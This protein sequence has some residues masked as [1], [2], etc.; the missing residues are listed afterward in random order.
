MIVAACM[1]ALIA[2][3]WGASLYVRKASAYLEA[4]DSVWDSLYLAAKKVIEDPAMP[5]EFAGFAAASVICAGCGC[6]TRAI[7]VDSALSVFRRRKKREKSWPEVSPEQ[8]AAFDAV[9]L[10][11][12]YYDSLRAPLSGLI[13]RKL[14]VPGLRAAA[15]GQAKA[16]RTTVKRIARS[17]RT[18]IEH[19]IEGRKLLAS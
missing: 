17:S 11:A 19:R 15:T 8:A 12:I 6:L 3:Y 18:A 10:N 16:R 14:T 4:S 7:L 5:R 9:V 13:L 1:A 2:I